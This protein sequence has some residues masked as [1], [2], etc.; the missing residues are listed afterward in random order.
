MLLL[1]KENKDKCLPSFSDGTCTVLNDCQ[2]GITEQM[3]LKVIF[4]SLCQR[5]F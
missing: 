1:Q 3:N 5:S 4:I 2:Y